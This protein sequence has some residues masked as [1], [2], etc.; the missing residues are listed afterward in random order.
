MQKRCT[1]FG[2]KAKM[3]FVMGH[4][5]LQIKPN[6][7]KCSKVQ[8]YQIFKQ[9]WIILISSRLIEFYWFGGPLGVGWGGWIWV[10]WC[11]CVGCPMHACLCMHARTCTCMCFKHDNFLQRLPPWGN[12]WEMNECSCL[13]A[14]DTPTPPPTPISNHPTHPNGGPS[15]SV[16]M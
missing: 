15:K 5:H 8:R 13:H 12:S 4:S 11:G 9:N 14:C 7:Y 10:G 3:L 1:Y 6:L 2:P 16:K